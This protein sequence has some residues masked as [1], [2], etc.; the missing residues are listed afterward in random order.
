MADMDAV[1]GIG[2]VT[3]VACW[4]MWVV[5]SQLCLTP[6]DGALR[7]FWSAECPDSADEMASSCRGAGIELGRRARQSPPSVPMTPHI[8]PCSKRS[9]AP[10]SCSTAAGTSH[11]SPFHSWRWWYRHPTYA[12][13]DNA[14]RLCA[15]LVGCGLAITW[16]RVGHRWR[17]PSAGAGIGRNHP[18]GARVR[19][20]LSLPQASSGVG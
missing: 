16:P 13:K 15:E 3:A 20:G 2:P 10:R 4:R 9:P 8:P 6:D 7:A 14:T 12:G 1:T 18:G 19:S 11:P 5:T 17:L